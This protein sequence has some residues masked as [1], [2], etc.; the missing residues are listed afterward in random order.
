[1][2][3]WAS[4]FL[5]LP[6]L[7]P[8]RPPFLCASIFVTFAVY[9]LFHILSA[10]AC[11][12]LVNKYLY[13]G[14]SSSQFICFFCRCRRLTSRSLCWSDFEN[15]TQDHAMMCGCWQRPNQMRNSKNIL[16]TSKTSFSINT[17]TAKERY[18]EWIRV[19]CAMHISSKPFFLYFVEGVFDAIEIK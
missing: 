18:R 14:V 11:F 4:A 15:R 7:T 3:L 8:S 16:L 1:M 19:R 2:V 17:Q 12:Y 13:N 5:V 10:D 9:C 6:V